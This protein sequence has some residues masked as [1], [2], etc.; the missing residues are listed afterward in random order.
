M[1]RVAMIACVYPEPVDE[2][3]QALGRGRGHDGV[4]RRDQFGP[5]TAEHLDDL[6]PARA[7]R[8]RVRLLRLGDGAGRLHPKDFEQHAQREDRR[9]FMD[10][11]GVDPAALALRS[12]ERR[13]NQRRLANAGVTCHPRPA[14]PPLRHLL[15]E[16]VEL[17][18]FILATDE[19]A[20]STSGR[21]NHMPGRPETV[22]S[23]PIVKRR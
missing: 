16:P 18:K 8:I 5:I 7:Q 10:R 9:L 12:G 22:T 14:A 1:S 4:V 15:H 13:G 3:N 6:R 20:I 21:C 23:G 17:V 2:G 19:H 11:R